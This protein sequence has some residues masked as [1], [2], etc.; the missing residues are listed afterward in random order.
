[1]HRRQRLR[2]CAQIILKQ[3]ASAAGLKL[4]R[5]TRLVKLL[6]LMRIMRLSR[7]LGSLVSFGSPWYSTVQ[8]TRTR[9]HVLDQQ[10]RARP[11]LD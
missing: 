6:K 7:T 4:L 8:V 3:T 10:F 5:A 9:V 2:I 11:R 1:M